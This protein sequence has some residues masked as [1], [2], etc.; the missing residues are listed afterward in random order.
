MLGTIISFDIPESGNAI[1]RLVLHQHESV[2]G[3]RYIVTSE[4]GELWYV[5]RDTNLRDDDTRIITMFK[6]FRL[7]DVDG[8]DSKLVEIYRKPW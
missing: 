7:D 1:V 8:D 5:A 3:K 4:G 2:T 6:V